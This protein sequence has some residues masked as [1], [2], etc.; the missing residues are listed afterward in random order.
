MFFLG[1]LGS[2]GFHKVPVNRLHPVYCKMKP[3]VPELVV[4]LCCRR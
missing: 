2:S 4:W 1:G 3:F